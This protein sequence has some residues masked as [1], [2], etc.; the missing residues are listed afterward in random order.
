[1]RQKILAGEPQ[2]SN[3]WASGN[4]ANSGLGQTDVLVVR[5]MKRCRPLR[6][7]MFSVSVDEIRKPEKGRCFAAYS[8]T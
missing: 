3:N 5:I 2:C 6:V 1:M 8:L 7:V 4:L